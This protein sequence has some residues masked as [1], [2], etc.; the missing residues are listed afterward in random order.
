MGITYGKNKFDVDKNT[1]FTSQA[2]GFYRTFKHLS[3]W[4]AMK[5][6]REAECDNNNENQ[7]VTSVIQVNGNG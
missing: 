6:Q 2:T 7:S 5:K 1:K 4:E 3:Y